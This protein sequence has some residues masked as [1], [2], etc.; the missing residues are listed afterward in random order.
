MRTH[1]RSA[2]RE[3]STNG[4]VAAKPPKPIIYPEGDGKPMAESDLHRDEMVRFIQAFQ[5]AFAGRPDVY[6]SGNLLLYYEEGNPRAVVAPDVFVVKGVPKHRRVIYKL[7]EEG[8]APC[9]VLEVASRSTK[10]DDRVR[11]RDLYARLGVEEYILYDPRFPGLET[12]Y[13][14]L[15]GYRLGPDGYEPMEV[16]ED[17]GLLSDELGLRLVLE[18]GLLQAY[19]RR[20]GLRLLSHRERAMEEAEARQAAESR[21]AALEALLRDRGEGC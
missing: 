1:A 12:R 7:W 19:D 10:H 16:Q 6:V 5:E 3:P 9:F 20:T 4:A 15:Q 8:V 14:P 21:I 2:A 18:N 13:P 17:G 11:K